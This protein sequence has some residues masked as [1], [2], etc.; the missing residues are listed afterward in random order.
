MCGCRVEDIL[1]FE[2]MSTLVDVFIRAGVDRVRLTG[3]EPLLRRDLPDLVGMLARKPAIRDLA[4]T[5]NG[6]MLAEHAADAAR[7]WTSSPDGQPR[8]ATPDRFQALTRFDALP[9]VLAGIEEGRNTFRLA[10]ARRGHHPRH[11]RRRAGASA[12]VRPRP[13][14]RGSVHRI[15][16]RRRRDALVARSRHVAPGHAVGARSANMGRSQKSWKTRAPRPIASGCLTER[17]SA[18]SRRRPIRSAAAATKPA[19]G[20]RH[21]VPLPLCDGRHRSSHA[22][23]RGNVSGRSAGARSQ[24]NG[25]RAA[26]AEPRSVSL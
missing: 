16:G 21:V 6:V 2:E 5:T 17:C 14:R 7:G 3:G 23:A 4:L 22:A 10:Q 26:I 24:G 19:D 11:E 25:A 9:Q 15:H 8:Y 20:R 1:H 13:R 18:S 12:G